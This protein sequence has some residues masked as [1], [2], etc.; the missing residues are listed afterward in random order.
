[1]GFTQSTNDESEVSPN[2][3]VGKVLGPEHFGRVRC[4][5]LG[6]APTNSFRNTRF[7]LSD[8]SIASSSA[9]TSSTSSD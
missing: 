7:Q 9:A 4:M 6:A 3:V 8:L 5:G 1:V 2:D